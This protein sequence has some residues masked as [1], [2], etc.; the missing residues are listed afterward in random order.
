MCF[1]QILD[2][3]VVIVLALRQQPV[4]ERA[5]VVH[6]RRVHERAAELR[7]VVPAERVYARDEIHV[8]LYLHVVADGDD[9]AR[10]VHGQDLFYAAHRVAE[11]APRLFESFIGPQIFAYFILR[12]ALFFYE[13][14]RENLRF[15]ECED[16]RRPVHKKF[17]PSKQPR[18][19][20]HPIPPLPSYA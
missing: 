10:N 8:A 9:A 18:L 2:E 1:L 5:P 7:N 13:H 15:F 16:I 19:V 12:H 14:E 6:V 3:Q 11:I 4:A 17:R 20:L